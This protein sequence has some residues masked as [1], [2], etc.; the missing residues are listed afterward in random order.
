MSSFLVIKK[1]LELSAGTGTRMLVGKQ[2]RA[3]PAPPS[4]LPYDSEVEFIESTGTQW[5]DTGIVPNTTTVA[6]FK[7]YN[8]EATGDVIF[9][10]YAGSDSQDW[11]FF[12]AWEGMYFDR[13]NYRISDGNFYPGSWRKFELGNYYVKDLQTG[14]TLLQGSATTFTGYSNITLGYNASA[15]TISKNKWGYVKIYQNGDLVFDAIPVRVGQI[16]YMYDRV[17]QQLLQNS[18]SGNFVL[19]N[20]VQSSQVGYS[21]DATEDYAV[22]TTMKKHF[23]FNISYAVDPRNGDASSLYAASFPSDKYDPLSATP[24][25]QHHRFL[26]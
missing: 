18:G 24:S 9:G 12:N 11:R 19:G 7:V 26:G 8:V 1:N 16:G 17:S 21:S 6:Q 15:N 3:I 4:P 22:V 5:I 13:I 14:T 20:D 25:Y 23:D 2:N 10:Y